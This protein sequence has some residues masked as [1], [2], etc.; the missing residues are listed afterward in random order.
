MR[1]ESLGTLAGEIF[2]VRAWEKSAEAVVARKRG[3]PRGAKGRRT[4][5]QTVLTIAVRRRAGFRNALNVATAAAIRAVA[6][7]RT[8]GFWS[9][10]RPRAPSR[11]TGEGGSQKVLNEDGMEKVLDPDHVG[12]AYAQVKRNGGAGGVDGMS[13]EA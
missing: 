5:K 10:A 7:G 4:T 6:E 11:S 12:L 3:K 13:V 2:R 8:G 1:A 9:E